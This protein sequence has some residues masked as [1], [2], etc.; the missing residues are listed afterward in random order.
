MKK[1][2]F[3]LLLCAF[4]WISV[5]AR[6]VVV[7]GSTITITLNA[8]ENFNDYNFD[9]VD[10]TNV[11]KL[12]LEGDF[13]SGDLQKFTNILG[14]K[15]SEI[16]AS[17]ATF[18][19]DN[20]N[21][22][23]QGWSQLASFTFPDG[24]TQI[25]AE[26]FQRCAFTEFTVPKS[27]KTIG[28]KA[29]DECKSLKTFTIPE[30]S[31]LEYIDASC[32]TQCNNITDV[33]INVSVHAN[34]D[35]QSEYPLIP[36]CPRATF[37]FETTVDQ[38]EVTGTKRATLHFPDTEAD[39]NYYCGEWKKGLAFT[40]ENLVF[41][42]DGY[43]VKDEETGN[44]VF[45]GPNNGWQEFA[46]TDS[47]KEIV[48]TGSFLRTYSSNTPYVIA[49]LTYKDTAT[50]EYVTVPLYEAFRAISYD[51]ARNKV[52]L[53]KMEDV[54]PENTG[55]ILRSTRAG[56]DAI[57][58][59]EAAGNKYTWQ[60]YRYG[61]DNLLETSITPTEIG[62]VTLGADNKVA[63]RNFGLYKVGDDYQFVRYKKGTI[64]EN[65]AYLKLSATQFT[66]NNESATEGPGS[67]LDDPQN[68][69]VSLFFLED[70]ETDNNVNPTGISVVNAKKA[71]KV[72]YNLQGMKVENPSK[73]IYI[74]NGK[75]VIK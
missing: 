4:A 59:L 19:T 52:N 70:E 49:K 18:G 58:Y 45:L 21:M 17:N 8:G 9:D 61:T 5:N 7:N 33:Y 69:K 25:P 3:T 67:G 44:N 72:Y 50:G 47:E 32:F 15:I 11:T 74:Y 20:S 35:T 48:V 63:Y 60:I 55:M 68:S 6:S 30:R 24:I 56:E 28:T 75:K 57:V 39:F 40:H 31:A 66:N 64:R 65:R 62:P 1:K 23:F 34:P 38:T 43:Y 71:D 54:T 27:V 42:K 37:D 29:F 14:S 16:D 26:C 2:L 36:Y 46:K 13:V 73:G 22:K 51:E 53:K 12:V 41:F 10:V